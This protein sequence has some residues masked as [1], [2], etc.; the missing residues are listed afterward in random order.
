VFA[1]ARLFA[2]PLTP[3]HGAVAA[4]LW[5]WVLPQA[6]VTVARLRDRALS[7]WWALLGAPP[8][9]FTALLR[10]APDDPQA[11]ALWF[12]AQQALAVVGLPALLALVVVCG[13][14]PSRRRAGGGRLSGAAD[15]P[16]FRPG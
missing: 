4:L 5:A 12:A 8:L 6:W 1:A 10:L 7:P 15:R 13:L 2:P 14:L 11:S 16:S 3:V 9:L